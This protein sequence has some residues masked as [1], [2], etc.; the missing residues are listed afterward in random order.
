MKK[1]VTHISYWKFETGEDEYV[2]KNII[3]P[4]GYREGLPKGWYCWVYSDDT[5]GF[6][7]W[8][9]LHCPTADATPRFNSGNP[10][11]TVFIPSDKEASMFALSFSEFL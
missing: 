9:K 11:V 10:M 3:C 8:M 5:Y 2:G 7:D 1:I 6:V 4:T